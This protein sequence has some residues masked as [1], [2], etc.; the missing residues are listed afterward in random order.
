MNTQ[1]PVDTTLGQS[2]YMA[3]LPASPVLGTAIKR[4]VAGGEGKVIYGWPTVHMPSHHI[5]R[6]QRA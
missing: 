5:A 4:A 6:L 1:C 3:M 2:L